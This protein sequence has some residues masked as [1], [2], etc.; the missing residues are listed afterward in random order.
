L[1]TLS[2]GTK[3]KWLQHK[4]E[5]AAVDHSIGVLL[6]ELDSLEGKTLLIITSDHGESFVDDE[7]LFDHGVNLRYPCLNVPLVMRCEGVVPVGVRDALVGNADLAPTILDL[8][9]IDAGDLNPDGRSLVPT[10]ADKD[11]WPERLIPIQTDPLPVHKDTISKRLRR[12]GVR[13]K[14]LSFQADFDRETNAFVS[15]ELFDHRE[16]P[17]E[18]HNLYDSR[19][20][21]AAR[22]L[23]FVRATFYPP[24]GVAPEQP[25]SDDPEMI[26][27]LKALGYLK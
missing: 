15:A 6:A 20:E 19:P 7:Y 2:R 12:R 14:H 4:G 22:L 23:G 21:I 26:E 10:F 25:I 17:R 11:P 18:L 24:E 13:S 16:D 3:A 1:A 27:R 5:V 8:L 9:G